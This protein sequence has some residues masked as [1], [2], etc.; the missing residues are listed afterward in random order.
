MDTVKAILLDETGRYLLQKRSATQEHPGT[1]DF[2]G[3]HIEA[4]ETPIEALQRELL[5]ELEYVPKSAVLFAVTP[6]RE[7]GV[8]S[9]FLCTAKSSDAFALKEGEA[10]AFLTREEIA[11]LPL[12][13]Y[14]LPAIA[15]VAYK[16]LQ[17]KETKLLYDSRSKD[18][19]Y[20]CQ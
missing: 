9:F 8:R 14:I 5:E 15:R 6:R 1:W 10:Y 19:S 18:Q 2:F 3:G 13:D 7:G 20:Q 4:S 17:A 16:F 11:E 12:R